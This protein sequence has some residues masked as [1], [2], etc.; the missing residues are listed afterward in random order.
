[1]KYLYINGI[2]TK[3][4]IIKIVVQIDLINFFISDRLLKN[5]Y[6]SPHTRLH[7]RPRPL[8]AKRKHNL[9]TGVHRFLG[10]KSKFVFTFLLPL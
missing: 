10:F 4:N 8:S 9:L 6:Q 5:Y 3:K 1:M 2:E 7:I